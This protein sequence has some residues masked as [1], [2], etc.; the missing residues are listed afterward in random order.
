MSIFERVSVGFAIAPGF[1]AADV[2]ELQT[3]WRTLV[4]ALCALASAKQSI[5]AQPDAAETEAASKAD[6]ATRAKIAAESLAILSHIDRVPRSRDQFDVE[7]LQNAFAREIERA[8][9]PCL[10]AHGRQ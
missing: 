10:A 3:I 5:G 8:V 9:Q 6:A 2:V 7:L 4:V 1:R